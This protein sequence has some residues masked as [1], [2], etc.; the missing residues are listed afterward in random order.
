M[1]NLKLFSCL[2]VLFLSASSVQASHIAGGDIEWTCL[3]N[4][5]YEITL[6]LYTDCDGISP[7]TGSVNVNIDNTCGLATN[8][9]NLSYVNPPGPTT[10]D[11]G[12][13]ISQLCSADSLNSSCLG[14]NL[15]GMQMTQYTGIVTLPAGCNHFTASWSTC[16]R[17]ALVVNL[18]GPT[19]AGTYVE[20]NIYTGND[21]CDNSPVFTAQPI[22]YVCV[23][24]PVFYNMGAYDPDADSLVYS[25]LP[26]RDNSSTTFIPYNAGYTATSPVPGITLNSVTGEISFTPT[27]TGNFV[28]VV[29]V[30]SFDPITGL[31]V[32]EVMR[33]IQFTAIPCSNTV[34]NLPT[35]AV[36]N[37]VG[38][39]TQTGPFAFEICIGVSIGFDI[40]FTDPDVG[41]TLTV[42]SN[43]ASILPG[44][45]LSTSGA[46]PLT[47]S[48]NWTA[49]ANTAGTLPV[50]FNINDGACPVSG[51]TT[52]TVVITMTPGVSAGSDIFICEQDTLPINVIGGTI[53]QWSVLSGPPLVVGQNI[54]CD[55]CA[56]LDL[57]PTASTT[58]L[59][60][61]DVNGNC[62]ATDTLRVTLTPPFDIGSV[63]LNDISCNGA[64]DGEIILGQPAGL[65][66]GP[67]TWELYDAANILVSTN[68]TPGGHNFTGLAPGTYS[69]TLIEPDG[70][71]KD[72]AG[73]VLN[74][75][76]AMTI[77]TGDTLIC[78]SS[79]AAIY[80]SATGGNGS[81]YTYNWSGFTGN[82]PHLVSPTTTTYYTVFASDQMGCTSPVDSFMVDM[83][84]LLSM[85]PTWTDS[86]CIDGEVTASVSVT[87]GNGGPYN[88]AWRYLG[89]GPVGTNDTLV[90]FVP[91]SGFS[92]L[93]VTATDNCGTPAIID[94]LDIHWYAPPVPI[95][96]PSVVEGCYPVAVDYAI[97]TPAGQVGSLCEWNFGDGN[98]LN[99]SCG[100]TSHTYLFPGCYDVDLTI[101][102]PQGCPGDSTFSQIICVR[103]YPEAEFIYDPVET[104]VFNPNI[105]FTN[106]SEDA[107]S[108]VW[109]F[110]ENPML[111]TSTA[112][113]PSFTFPDN[114]EGAYPVWLYATNQY[115]CVD[116]T[117]R[118]V[119]IDGYFTLY[120]P[121]AFTPDGDGRNDLFQV[122]GQ[123]VSTVDFDFQVF[124]R[125]GKVIW[126]TNDP[127][128]GWDG[129][130]ES[131]G[132]FAYMVRLQDKYSLLY[133]EYLGH[134][135]LVR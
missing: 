61:S 43:I 111:G 37:T 71:V 10:P 24:Q 64:N 55:T 127:T 54:S 34:P 81:T 90:T 22:P 80:A 8:S 35:A 108:Y 2:V 68:T 60:T 112:V 3:G 58:Y 74:Q 116:S 78:Q 17:N 94:T 110:G 118:I 48:V 16:C 72:T 104:N 109:T 128:A 51:I 12:V 30:Q 99:G 82:G 98:V 28:V 91:T 133:K 73:L 67:Y 114:D 83:H 18:D 75:P 20:A 93:E 113:D 70:C 39:A 85:V 117:M 120:I 13:N 129:A 9:V 86:V 87:G 21:P 102:S 11:G 119:E 130:G 88:Y 135:T 131:P 38:G 76:T 57:I 105:N 89:F 123:G 69:V 42:T 79:T 46:N 66:P 25:F 5:Q 50:T 134:V 97:Q 52:Q 122:R 36:T 132:V 44:A 107:I 121:N 1:R 56:I 101:Y 27:I 59:L 6:S 65:A 96:S 100:T 33:D 126:Q 19:G 26:A 92:Q 49:V 77:T 7:P 84:P 124:D 40:V 4:G 95:I 53:Y 23:N 106:Q 45:T 63:I 115:G 47:V 125:W 29:R 14:G 31:L 62:I 41:D 32:G 15:P 103:P